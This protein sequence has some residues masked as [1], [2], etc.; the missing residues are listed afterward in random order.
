MLF[1]LLIIVGAITI[2]IGLLGKRPLFNPFRLVDLEPPPRLGSVIAGSVLIFAALWMKGYFH[3]ERNVEKPRVWRST[4]ASAT[5]GQGTRPA[6]PKKETE[7]SD[8][9]M[10]GVAPG[11]DDAL[12][13]PGYREEVFDPVEPKTT[14]QALTPIPSP[15]SEEPPRSL[16]SVREQALRERDQKLERQSE[17]TKRTIGEPPSKARAPSAKKAELTKPKVE[18]QKTRH[19]PIESA[20]T[21]HNVSLCGDNEAGV[22]IVIRDTL[23]PQQLEETI[24]LYIGG[25]EAA[26]YRLDRDNPTRSYSIKVPAAV[27]AS[28]VLSGHVVYEGEDGGRKSLNGD[29]EIQLFPGAAYDIMI[30]RLPGEYSLVYLSQAP[31]REVNDQRVVSEQW[32]D[33]LY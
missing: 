10:V 1:Y 11:P 6:V 23:A 28:Y 5:I 4:P 22:T 17:R 32:A 24:R 3:A 29:G 18:R 27:A 13:R 20:D 8:V 14:A 2:L 25:K 15:V 21:H 26:T 33:P 9:E 31:S 30:D 16:E 19:T 7:S 12:G